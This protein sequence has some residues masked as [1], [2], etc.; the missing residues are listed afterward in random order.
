LE[1][2]VTRRPRIAI[3]SNGDELIGPEGF[4]EVLAGR[5]I[6]DSNA[7]ALAAAVERA[8]GEPVGLGIAADERA[9]LRAALDRGRSADALITTAGASVGDHDLIKDVLAELGFALDFWRVAMKPGSP[10]S[11]GRLPATRGAD[12]DAAALLPV[13][14]LPGNPVSALVTFEVLVRPAIRRLLG[15]AVPIPP[16]LRVR[17]DAAFP[18]TPRLTHYVRARLETDER[19]GWRA[20]PTGPQGSGIL[21]SVAAAD[22]LVVVPPAPHALPAGSL[23]DAIPLFEEL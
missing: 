22:A 4:A 7:W 13:F 17:L 16:P 20:R 8:G 2:R 23:A 10:F 6:V 1:V 14:G 9:S 11:F 15:R 18:A 3:L 12:A 5:K 21:S 19:G